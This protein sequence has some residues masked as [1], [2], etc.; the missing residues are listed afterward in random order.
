M[1]GWSEYVGYPT[2]HHQRSHC[3][4]GPVNVSCM[5]RHFPSE[6]QLP[7]ENEVKVN[8]SG[9]LVIWITVFG[10]VHLIVTHRAHGVPKL[11]PMQRS[12]GSE[13]VGGQGPVEGRYRQLA[14]CGGGAVARVSGCARPL[15][16]FNT[17]SASATFSSRATPSTQRLFRSSCKPASSI[18]P[19]IFPASCL[20]L[21]SIREYNILPRNCV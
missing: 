3:R 2:G 11:R 1:I 13:A 20:C 4:G 5:M 10:Q 21:G 14:V 15:T 6:R 19:V 9:I 8:C 17:C 16:S 7:N 18:M 12:G